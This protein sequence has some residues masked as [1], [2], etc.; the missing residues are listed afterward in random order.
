MEKESICAQFASK[1]HRRF[2]AVKD[3]SRVGIIVEFSRDY[4]LVNGM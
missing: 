3:E 1:V 2:Y 4:I